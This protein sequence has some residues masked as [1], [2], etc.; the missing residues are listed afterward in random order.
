[1][2]DACLFPSPSLA[3][4]VGA[5]PGPV[6]SDPDTVSIPEGCQ[7]LL[8]HGDAPVADVFH[9]PLDEQRPLA[10]WMRTHTS[11]AI[12]FDTNQYPVNNAGVVV[13]SCG[14]QDAGNNPKAFNGPRCEPPPGSTLRP[15]FGPRQ[16]ILLPSLSSSVHPNNPLVASSIS[17]GLPR[18]QYRSANA[19]ERCEKKTW[20]SLCE[21]DF[22]QPQ[23]LGRH[24]K[25]KHEIKE[26][27]L[28]CTSFKW[29]RGRPYLYRKHLRTRHAQ[30][31]LPEV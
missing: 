19:A 26:S 23:V 17:S 21:T 6:S 2:K 27:C 9:D 15:C 5:F 24:K 11:T 16:T 12:P 1:M 30:I 7:N 29:S 14:F 8:S 25:D 10:V 3:Q 18:S 28:Y 13:D 31:P 20:C 22:S 4:E